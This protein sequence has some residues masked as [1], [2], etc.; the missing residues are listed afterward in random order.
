MSEGRCAEAV[1]R[2]PGA[3]ASQRLN[4]G[5]STADSLA[6]ASAHNW[7]QFSQSF[8]SEAGSRRLRTA[9]PG[10]AGRPVGRLVG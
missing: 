2:T 3:C 1:T 7:A 4:L 8:N 6:R 5:I 10:K 9:N